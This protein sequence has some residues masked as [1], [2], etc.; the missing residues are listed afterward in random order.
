VSVKEFDVVVADGGR[1]R[2]LVPV[3]FDPDAEWGAKTRHPVGGTINGR[4]VRGVV[5]AHDGVL[6]FLVGVAWLRDGTLETGDRAHVEIAPEGPQ[7]ADLADDV[8]AA[9]EA[10]PEAGEFFD[11]LAQFYRRAYLRWIDGT[12]RRPELRRQ[13]IATT[14]ELLEQGVKDYR[15]R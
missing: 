4:R 1:G 9:L 2:L 8:A 6:G 3:P 11:S 10:S 14:V 5:E 7:R 13:R 12:T 15:T